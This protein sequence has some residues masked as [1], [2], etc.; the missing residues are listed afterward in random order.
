MPRTPD[1]IPGE[2]DEEGIILENRAP[3]DVPV[4]AGGIRYVNGSFVFLDG[5]G[6]F[7]PRTGSGISATVHRTLRQLVHLADGGGPFEG[8]TTGAYRE[9]LPSTS[10]FPTS[11]IW[12]TDSGKTA[13]IVEHALTYNANKTVAT[14]QWKAYDTDGVT[15]LATVTDTMTYSGIF[16]TSRTRA[17]A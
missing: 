8:F 13:K 7:D 15:V 5:S 3:G 9:I 12:W 11:V 14:S 17:I 6:T 10:P 2:A 1:R 16:E 4:V